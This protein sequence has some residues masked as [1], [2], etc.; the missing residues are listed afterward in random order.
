[1]AIELETMIRKATFVAL[2]AMALFAVQAAD[3]TALLAAQ[4]HTM[5]CCGSM[6][7][8]PAHGFHECC[9]TAVSSPL[10]TVLP[11]EHAV[12]TLPSLSAAAHLLAAEVTV[13]EA[14][15]SEFE[16]PQHSPPE[17]YTLHS[18]FRI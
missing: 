6:P 13:A 15:C 11:Q 12:L 3:C 7:C 8:H 16:A 2:A 1:M 4:Q 14:F 5:S 18:S 9:K 10:P 17:L